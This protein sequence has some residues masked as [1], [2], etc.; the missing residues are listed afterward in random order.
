M[1][2]RWIARTLVT[3]TI[4]ASA[5]FMFVMPVVADPSPTP[6]GYTGALNMVVSVG[7]P[8][9]M[10]VDNPNGN[11]GMTTAVVNSAGH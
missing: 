8:H 5:A 4:V 10:S 9:A 1:T 3:V 11:A 2:M 6:N 7:M